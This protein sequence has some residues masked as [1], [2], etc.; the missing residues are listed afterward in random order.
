MANSSWVCFACRIAV[1]RPSQQPQQV[2]CPHCREACWA[3]GYKIPVPPKQDVR[4][5]QKLRDAQHAEHHAKQDAAAHAR[6][7]RRHE[8]EQELR[9]LTALPANPGREQSIKLLQRR[10][11]DL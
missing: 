8:L 7:R 1:R 10:L 2:P 11:E 6:V 4:A 5:W 3:L 9:R